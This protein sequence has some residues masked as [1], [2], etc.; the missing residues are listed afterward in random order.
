MWV[1]AG[2]RSINGAD[3]HDSYVTGR[4]ICG[5]HMLDNGEGTRSTTVFVIAAIDEERVS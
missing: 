2:D 3:E 1:V 5:V 4:G